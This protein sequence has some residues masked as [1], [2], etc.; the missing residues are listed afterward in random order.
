MMVKYGM[1]NPIL[2]HAF[3]SIRA[4]SP[5]ETITQRL[6]SLESRLILKTTE[7]NIED[8]VL[9]FDFSSLI[10]PSPFKTTTKKVSNPPVARLNMT[11]TNRRM[12]Q[13]KEQRKSVEKKSL[14]YK[15]SVEKK[16]SADDHS[17][18]LKSF[19]SLRS[20]GSEKT[21]KQGI[22]KKGTRSRFAY[23]DHS[24]SIQSEGSLSR[25]TIVE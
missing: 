7:E 24:N 12:A 6:N 2:G 1:T 20:M 22:L 21:P 3:S 16:K 19:S 9:I 18:S 5:S 4:L 25:V 17:R 14:E 23:K 11:R 8:S 10:H 15:R 13:P